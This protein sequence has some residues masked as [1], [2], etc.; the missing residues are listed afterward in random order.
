MPTGQLGFFTMNPDGTISYVFEGRVIAKGVDLE[1]TFNDPS[2]GRSYT[3]PPLAKDSVQWLDADSPGTPPVGS[4]GT[5]HRDAFGSSTPPNTGARALTIRATSAN[6]P[7]AI[8]LGLA[9]RAALS[10]EAGEDYGAGT[11]QVRALAGEYHRTIVDD[12]NRSS[13]IGLRDGPVSD[14]RMAYGSAVV[15]MPA[16][17]VG[18]VVPLGF[19][20]TTHL[21][22]ICWV[23]PF[24]HYSYSVPQSGV[25][26]TA[27]SGAFVT[28]NTGAA[29]S[30]NVG[31]ISL[32]R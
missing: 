17:I 27:S 19:A 20:W 7:P 13:F 15:T 14:L 18:V 32:G 2:V 4:I 5:T 8:P 9:N 28:N 29:Q 16:G 10:L 3:D 6:P 23:A 31:W 11:T 24:V 22:F 21:F 12:K 26:Q 1:S 25:V 30:A